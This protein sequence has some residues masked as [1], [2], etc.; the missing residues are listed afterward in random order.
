[1][2]SASANRCAGIVGSF[3]SSSGAFLPSLGAESVRMDRSISEEPWPPNQLHTHPVLEL[4]NYPSI[5]TRLKEK[6]QLPE[7][8]FFRVRF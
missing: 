5:M 4:A 6:R 3:A 7:K 2:P 1:M 8:R